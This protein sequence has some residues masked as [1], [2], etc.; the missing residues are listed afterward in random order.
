M[1]A[2]KGFSGSLTSTMGNGKKEKCS[3]EPGKTY[4]EKESKTAR[5]GYHCCENPFE[6]L[7]YYGL[8][9][10]NRFFKVEAS[11]DIDEDGAERIS[12]TEITLLKELSVFEFALEGMRYI[13]LHPDRKKWQQSHGNV[14]VRE[15]YAEISMQGIAIARGRNPVVRGPAGSVLG[16]IVEGDG[17]ITGAKL[18]IQDRAMEGKWCRLTPE[19]KIQEDKEYEKKA[20]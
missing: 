9:G 14:L 3:F 13:I 1:I 20:G 8:D 17:G 2:Y 10:S 7:G 15:D 18:F 5:S 12:C 11:G 19:R 4:H 6:C 16:L